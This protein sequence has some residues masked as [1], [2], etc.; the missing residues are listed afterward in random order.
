[1][2]EKDFTGH[3]QWRRLVMATQIFALC[4][5]VITLHSVQLPTQQAGFILFFATLNVLLIGL[6]YFSFSL[7][8]LT[9]TFTTITTWRLCA[10]AHLP[11]LTYLFGIIT[12]IKLISFV[13]CAYHNLRLQR[14]GIATQ[15][16]LDS[17]YEWQLMF[18]R[19]F[20]GFIFIPHFAEKL[21]AGTVIRQADITAFT[22]L[23]LH[24]PLSF[25]IIAGLMEFLGGLA[26]SIGFLTRLT[27]ICLSIYLIVSSLLG[28]HFTLGFI[29]ASPGGGWEYP[30]FWTSLIISFAIFGGGDFSVDRLLK[31]QF[32]LPRWFRLLQGTSKKTDNAL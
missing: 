8:F 22:H 19:M 7:V 13:L 1:M 2:L 32:N 25:V 29:W 6:R 12:V 14:Q 11:T 3:P 9:T 5:T 17:P 24:N 26:L 31:D 10:L 23:G 30:F 16:H 27:A 20:T 18:I 15:Q 4:M 28:K 21:F